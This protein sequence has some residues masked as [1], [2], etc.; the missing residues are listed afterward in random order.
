[1][2]LG[3]GASQ[4]ALTTRSGSNDFHGSVYWYNRNSALAANDWFNNASGTPRNRINV[5]Q[6]GA[7]V[8]GRILR[9][10]LF[11]YTNYELYRNKAQSSR[12]RTVLTDTAKTGVFQYRDAANNLH[13]AN[14]LSIR[15]FSI[16]PTI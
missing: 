13:Q 6:P 5:N 16:N 9:D 3:G 11:F 14:L 8:G 1:V 7:A 12:L 2:A 10:K 15:G 4:F